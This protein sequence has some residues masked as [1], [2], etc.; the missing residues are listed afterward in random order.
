MSAS[1]ERGAEVFVDIWADEVRRLVPEVTTLQERHARDL[2]A[3]DHGEEWSPTDHDLYE[4]FRRL[5]AAQHHLIWAAHQLER[6]SARL[7]RER[8]ETP[9]PPDPVLADLRNALEHLD[10]AQLD[11]DQATATPGS[12]PKKNRSMRRLPGERLLVGTQGQ[13]LFNLIGLFDMKRGS[14]GRDT[15]LSLT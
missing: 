14:R 11:D 8:G 15:M 4:R 10:E 9:T 2:R 5:W 7:A 13:R 6:W 12:D 1:S 3:A